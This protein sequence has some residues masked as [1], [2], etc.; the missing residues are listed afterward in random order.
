MEEAGPNSMLHTFHTAKD[1]VSYVDAE[2]ASS[3]AVRDGVWGIAGGGS[4]V[5]LRPGIR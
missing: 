5:M 4:S 1:I 2:V 3:D